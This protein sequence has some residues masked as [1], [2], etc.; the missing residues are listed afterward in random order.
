MFA[1]APRVKMRFFPQSPASL[2]Y[3]RVARVTASV[4]GLRRNERAV[5][6]IAMG[7]GTKVGKPVAKTGPP[8]Y[9]APGGRP[10]WMI[11]VFG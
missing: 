9:F 1:A 3:R 6:R 5:M 7:I 4:R 11:V 8:M 10:G 2:A